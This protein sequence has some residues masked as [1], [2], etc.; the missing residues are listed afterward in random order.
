MGSV[1][2]CGQGFLFLL[3]F[4]QQTQVV[5]EPGQG[6][7][8]VTGSKQTGQPPGSAEPPLA[9]RSCEPFNAVCLIC[10]LSKN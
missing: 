3:P 7:C 10:F 6:V 5:P 4:Q 1:E 9:K 8:R 2:G